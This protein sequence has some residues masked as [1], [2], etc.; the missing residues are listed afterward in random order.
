[1]DVHR[2]VQRGADA[3]R[4]ADVVEVG[5]R[6]DDRGDVVERPPDPPHGL[7]QRAPRGRHAG[8]DDGEP[9]FV[10]D[11]VPVRV[12]I[13]DAVHPGR[14]VGLH[15]ASSVPGPRWKK[16]STSVTVL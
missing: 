8:V 7:L 11:E 2:H 10:L 9:P 4:A 15:H 5:V 12:R 16:R 6:E 13:L 14:D 1:V 3:L